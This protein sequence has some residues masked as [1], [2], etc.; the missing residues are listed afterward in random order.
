MDP[1][2]WLKEN[3]RFFSTEMNGYS[4]PPIGP[5][6]STLPLIDRDGKILDLGAGNAMLLKF[7]IKFSGHELSPFGID[8]IP[9]A[10]SQ[11]KE[12]IFPDYSPLRFYVDDVNTHKFSEGPH[13]II[14]SN[15]FYA[16]NMREFTEKCLDNLHN[17]GRL[18][19]RIHD[20]VLY[21]N[22]VNKLDDLPDFKNLG[23]KVSRGQGLSFCV[24]D[25]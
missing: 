2:T 16:K 22:K 19:Y 4:A 17:N 14:I 1:I 9:Q 6:L 8:I 24:F 21:Y 12:K 7:L 5:Y 25:K 11:A 15:P 13:N 23:M 10:I 3:E 18:I 20:D